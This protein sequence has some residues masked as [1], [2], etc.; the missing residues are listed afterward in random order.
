MGVKVRDY[1]VGGRKAGKVYSHE[2]YG[3]ISIHRCSGRGIDL[4]GSDIKHDNFFDLEIK[5]AEQINDLGRTWVYPKKSKITIR[6]SASQFVEMI[7]GMNTSGVPCTL[8]STAEDGHIK[9]EAPPSPLD[10]A[11]GY[12]DETVKKAKVIDKKLV[13]RAEDI[14]TAKG[15]IKKADK[16]EL[17]SLIRSLSQQVSSN[18]DFAAEQGKEAVEK[19]K[20]QGMA[21]IDARLQHIITSTGLKVLQDEDMVQ[22]LLEEKSE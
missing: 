9:Y 16:D 12:V 14:L 6:L 20:S 1:E 5:S 10:Y 4:F 17:L 11:E 19:T 15:T 2:S 18:L 7:S 8:V 13:S 3:M 21:E 22:K